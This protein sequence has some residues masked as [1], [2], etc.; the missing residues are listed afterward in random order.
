MSQKQKLLVLLCTPLIVSIYLINHSQKPQ[1][2]KE[3]AAAS[4][5]KCT[6]TKF[7]LDPIDSTKQIA[8]LFNDLG[9]HSYSISSSKKRAQE[10]FNQGLNL[11]Y[12]FNHSKAHRAF[13]EATR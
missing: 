9:N 1:K 6:S 10:F 13:L 4:F 11:T 7:L 3:I 2:P 8:P 12:A 5:I